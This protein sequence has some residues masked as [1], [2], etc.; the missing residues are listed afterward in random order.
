MPLFRYLAMRLTLL[1]VFFLAAAPVVLVANDYNLIKTVFLPQQ[2]F[3]GDEVEL[4]LEIRTPFA[5]R[6]ILPQIMPETIWGSI[7]KISILRDGLEPEVRINFV[8]HA[9]G[10]R[11]LPAINLGSI[12]IE[13]ISIY[14]SS[15][16]EPGQVE[17]SAVQDQVLLP[18][19]LPLLLAQVVFLLLIPSL[20]I[21]ALIKGSPLIG[22]L[23]RRWQEGQAWR[24]LSQ[25]LKQLQNHMEQMDARSFYISIQRDARTYLSDRLKIS[26]LSATTSE[27]V[28]IL[29]Q[30]VHSS[31]AIMY[32]EQLFQFGDRVKFAN[33]SANYSMRLNQLHQLEA[34]LRHIEHE[35]LIHQ[36][37]GR[38]H[39]DI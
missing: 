37:K 8:A 28:A 32:I 29:R 21:L 2:Y 27:L 11:T 16:L 10:T 35:Q 38:A 25:E 14:V 26:G 7:N 36:G 23:I 31:E 9:V 12:T 4:R 30:H 34:A 20:V 3:V 5:D 19:T 6:L 24:K 17:L 1:L 39:L 22:R 13:G 15:I 33:E 18:A